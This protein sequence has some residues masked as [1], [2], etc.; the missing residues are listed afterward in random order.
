MSKVTYEDAI[1]F[2]SGQ[3]DLW[4]AFCDEIE[5]RRNAYLGDIKSHMRN[6]ATDIHYFASNGAMVAVDDLLLEFRARLKQ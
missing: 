1:T 4:T 3:E 5:E 2:F 6:P